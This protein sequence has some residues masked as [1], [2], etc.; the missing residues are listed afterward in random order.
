MWRM[1]VQQAPLVTDSEVTPMLQMTDIVKSYG[2][3]TALA[4]VDF[5][6]R[7]G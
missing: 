1:P 6:L 2:P 5:A 3:V 7:A 4:G